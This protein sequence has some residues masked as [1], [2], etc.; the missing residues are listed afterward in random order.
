M[1]IK[2]FNLKNISKKLK[3]P[4]NPIEIEKI[5]GFGLRIAKFKNSYHWHS[6]KNKD[7]LFIVL[8]GKISI[9]TEIGNVTLNKMEG[10]KIPKKV[11]HCPVAIKP[12]IILMIEKL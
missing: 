3:K 12:S 1:Q 2:K 10:V 4:W 9:K 6:H 8:E 11:K 5:D 7:E